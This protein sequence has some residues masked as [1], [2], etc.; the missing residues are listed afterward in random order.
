[1]SRL[2]IKAGHWALL[3]L[4]LWGGA[5]LASGLLRFDAYGLEEG[6]ARAILLAWSVADRVISTAFVM[7]FPDLRLLL[8]LPLGLYWPGS[9][10]AIKVF[11]LLA[12]F[13]GVY[14]LHGWS[15][16]RHGGEGALLA[17]GLMLIA[18]VT[19]A[20]I[21][22]VGTGPFLLLAFAL[23]HWLN[24]TYR[25]AQRPLGG[26]FFVQLLLT[27][28]AVSLHPVGLAYPLA[29]FW[30]WRRD[31][32]DTRHQRHVYIGLGIA[33]G[34]TLL[35]S[36]G[37][38]TQAWFA[39]PVT[40]LS[41][42]LLGMDG[43][44]GEVTRWIVGL[45]M[46]L[47]LALI[48]LRRR[49]WTE[50]LAA[51]TLALAAILGLPAADPAW[52]M[53]TLATLLYLGIPALIAFNQ[54]LGQQGFMGQRGL[55]MFVLFVTATLFMQ[56]DKAHYQRVAA[57]LLNPTDQLILSFALELEDEVRT[58]GDSQEDEDFLAMSQWP[59]RTMLALRRPVLPLPPPYPDEQALLKN[60]AGT[61]HLIFDPRDPRN[62][63]LGSQL[64]RLTALSKTLLL[65][66]GGVVI[67]IDTRR[68]RSES[69]TQTPGVTAA[70]RESQNPS[71]TSSRNRSATGTSPAATH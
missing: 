67:A 51:R 27:A 61:T 4:L 52:V 39:N 40:T 37:W 8:F 57:N 7:G 29:L 49:L 14:L 41:G 50:D 66:P 35:L 34:L 19:I 5:I 6:A 63:R 64:A 46:S 12:C 55:V 53:V 24:Q 21:D 43:E 20:Q 33:A 16:H 18:P 1:M 69:I 62:R 38:E 2:R 3:I 70:A 23:G 25:R 60:I 48:L 22:A 30:E 71:D 68:K 45:V 42:A 44:P 32:L 47:L 56:G 59:A 54:T 10:V 11:T 13:T 15:R 17:S 28:F 26:W 9:M 31:P 58:A 36:L 65:E